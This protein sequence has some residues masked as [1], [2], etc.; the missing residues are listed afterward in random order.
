MKGA[1]T[2]GDVSWGAP[3]A[4]GSAHSGSGLA[5]AMTKEGSQGAELTAFLDQGGDPRGPNSQ[6]QQFW[7]LLDTGGDSAA[8]TGTFRRTSGSLG[9]LG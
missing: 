7:G 8:G 2:W 4:I 5:P 9:F 3:E 1:G 6:A